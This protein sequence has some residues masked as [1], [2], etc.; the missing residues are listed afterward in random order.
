LATF[1][2]N[3]LLDYIWMLVLFVAVD[4]PLNVGEASNIWSLILQSKSGGKLMRKLFVAVTLTGA[5]AVIPTIADSYQGSNYY[6]PAEEGGGCR[7]ADYMEEDFAAGVLYGWSIPD[8]ADGESVTI[9]SNPYPQ[10]GY[11]AGDF[12]F[13]CNNGTLSGGSPFGIWSN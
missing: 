11:A 1:G 6:S 5:F 13:T 3:H 8:L 9:S 10:N 12:T 2:K 4:I 7:T